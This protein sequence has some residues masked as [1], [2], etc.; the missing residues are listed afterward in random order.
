[1]ERSGDRPILPLG[2]DSQRAQPLAQGQAQ[3]PATLQMPSPQLLESFVH[4]AT[5]LNETME[6]LPVPPPGIT[7]HAVPNRPGLFDVQLHIPPQLTNDPDECKS[8]QDA[9]RGFIGAACPDT[10]SGAPRP[11]ANPNGPHS[12]VANR[13]WLQSQGDQD[14]LD[15]T[16]VGVLKVCRLILAL[17]GD[18]AKIAAIMRQTEVVEILTE[19]VAGAEAPFMVCGWSPHVVTF[20]TQWA[21]DLTALDDQVQKLEDAG[22]FDLA[23]LVLTAAILNT[24]NYHGGYGPDS[25]LAKAPLLVRFISNLISGQVLDNADD[26]ESAFEVLDSVLCNHLLGTQARERMI[27]A[28]FPLVIHVAEN[29]DPEAALRLLEKMYYHGFGEILPD[30]EGNCKSAMEL[31]VRAAAVQGSPELVAQVLDTLSAFKSDWAKELSTTLVEAKIANSVLES[32]QRTALKEMGFEFEHDLGNLRIEPPAH[33]DPATHGA[34]MI[35]YAESLVQ[36]STRPDH[37]VLFCLPVLDFLVGHFAD[38]PAQVRQRL[39]ALTPIVTSL[40]EDAVQSSPSSA[41]SLRAQTTTRRMQRLVEAAL[42]QG[43]L[44]ILPTL[45]P[46]QALNVAAWARQNRGALFAN[47]PQNLVDALLAE[48]PGAPGIIILQDQHPIDVQA[49]V[50]AIQPALEPAIKQLSALFRSARLARMPQVTQVLFQGWKTLTRANAL[51]CHTMLMRHWRI[52]APAN[53]EQLQQAATLVQDA[54]AALTANLADPNA[55]PAAALALHVATID[56][57]LENVVAAFN[58]GEDGAAALAWGMDVLNEMATDPMVSGALR[59]AHPNAAAWPFWACT[60]LM[61]RPDTAPEDCVLNLLKCESLAGAV[62]DHRSDMVFSV[63]IDHI[64]VTEGQTPAGNRRTNDLKA[65]MLWWSFR[66]AAGA[67]QLERVRFSTPTLVSLIGSLRTQL[68]FRL[69][70]GVPAQEAMSALLAELL[71]Q[72]EQLALEQLEG[73]VSNRRLMTDHPVLGVALLL[74][75]AAHSRAQGDVAKMQLLFARAL[76][77]APDLPGLPDYDACRKLFQSFDVG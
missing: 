9:I 44:D 75:F 56:F 37:L 41:G 28:C 19:T 62:P 15:A 26:F 76:S 46:Q 55:D 6:Q 50:A 20:A 70:P 21:C 27:D 49:A 63:Y 69:D 18:A 4:L 42:L 40:V 38:L 52:T 64:I 25:G 30:H 67:V 33:F 71:A 12:V 24:S 72:N 29:N 3:V 59:E 65:F 39:L 16:M 31:L 5:D 22:H 57:I 58:H 2:P 17:G 23:M 53:A 13:L 74:R 1:M 54:R 43:V 34:G 11:V 35:E 45:D 7:L 10:I 77:I 48:M 68:A 73:I 47:L 8:L 32:P 36:A 61:L 66:P 51:E 14:A 60:Q